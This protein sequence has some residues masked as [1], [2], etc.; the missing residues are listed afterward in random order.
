VPKWQTT[1][2]VPKW[3]PT[4]KVPTYPP[5]TTFNHT[6]PHLASTRVVSDKFSMKGL[7][8]RQQCQK[9][10]TS[11]RCLTG[12]CEIPLA[13]WIFWRTFSDTGVCTI[14]NS[15]SHDSAT[16]LRTCVVC[17]YCKLHMANR[18][19]Q[20]PWVPSHKILSVKYF[21]HVFNECHRCGTPRFTY[22]SK[23]ARTAKSWKDY[24]DITQIT[25]TFASNRNLLRSGAATDPL[26]PNV[27]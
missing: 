19:G 13:I 5:A 11:T 2:K 4:F 20:T 12:T 3:Q 25:M 24:R 1:F 7:L 8:L 10:I 26:K 9:K 18:P 23:W 6:H 17:T 14:R 16:A 22:L 21:H 27:Y 15:K